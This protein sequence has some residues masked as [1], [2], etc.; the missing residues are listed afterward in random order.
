MTRYEYEKQGYSAASSGTVFKTVTNPLFVF[1]SVFGVVCGAAICW[2]LFV[3]P[4]HNNLHQRETQLEKWSQLNRQMQQLTME[5]RNLS[6]TQL[7][8]YLVM[9]QKAA[10]DFMEVLQRLHQREIRLTQTPISFFIIPLCVLVIALA[11]FVLVLKTLN[12]R[13]LATVEYVL[14]LAPREMVQEI[15]ARHLAVQKNPT[16][17][18]L[19][20]PERSD[21]K[22]G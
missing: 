12:A 13:A 18:G 19:L 16:S 8:Q 2:Y 15:I 11:G 3:L 10:V 4:L 7:K 6:Q 5:N 20:P 21:G 1:G 22:T 9:N 17:Y 14:H